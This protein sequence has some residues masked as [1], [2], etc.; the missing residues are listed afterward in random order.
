MG[1]FL[2]PDLT[3]AKKR[4]TDKSDKASKSFV[5]TI[6]DIQLKVYLTAY[7]TQCKETLA[8]LVFVLA[9]G[10]DIG[11]CCNLNEP[12]TRLMH[13]SLLDVASMVFA[14]S[15]WK[16]DAEKAVKLQAAINYSLKAYNDYPK[17]RAE[18]LLYA[19]FV[20]DKAENGLLS[21]SDFASLEIYGTT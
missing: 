15:T 12:S 8:R 1:P 3:V 20:T 5:E 10:S 21:P 4:L 11:I 13:E 19:A 14:N 6:R 18:A 7:D 16:V 9:T 2:R 17:S